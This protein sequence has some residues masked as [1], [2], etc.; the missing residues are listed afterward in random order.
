[1]EQTFFESMG[2]AGLEKIHTQFIEWI[3]NNN[4]LKNDFKLRLL[5]DLIG[6]KLQYSPDDVKIYA[7]TEFESIDLLIRVGDSLI[8]LENK[9]TSS[10]HDN[11]LKRYEQTV[12]EHQN[13]K[14]KNDFFINLDNSKIHYILLE[15]IDEKAESDKW[16]CVSYK[17]WCQII[18]KSTIDIEMGDT[19]RLMINDYITTLKRMVEAIETVLSSPCEH[20]N[21]F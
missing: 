19:E 17:N 14:E 4:T 12:F 9:L 6:K 10:Q 18:C 2:I 21:I 3:M 1:M 20:Q 16:S 11:Q 5:Q 8:I 7:L 15:L 13:K